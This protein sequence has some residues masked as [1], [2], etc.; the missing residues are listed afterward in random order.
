LPEIFRGILLTVLELG[1]EHC[2]YS[3]SYMELDVDREMLANVYSLKV[4]YHVVVFIWL[5]GK[6]FGKVT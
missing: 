6:G 1:M 2:L 4:Y 3:C 5:T